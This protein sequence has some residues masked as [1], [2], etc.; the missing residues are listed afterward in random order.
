SNNQQG[1]LN[2]WLSFRSAQ[3]SLVAQF[4]VGA[5]RLSQV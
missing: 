5:N 4:S 2:T 3:A 1:K